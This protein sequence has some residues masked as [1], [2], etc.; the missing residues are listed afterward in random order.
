MPDPHSLPS[1]LGN[2]R[3]QAKLM[4]ANLAEGHLMQAIK[5]CVDF[6]NELRSLAFSP[7]EYYE[8]YMAVYDALDTFSRYLLQLHRLK[9]AKNKDVPFLTDL[10]E[11]VQYTGN[12]VPRL[13]LM[14]AIGTTCMAVENA[15]TK[16]IMKDMI[17]MCRGVQH[18]IRGLFLRHYL[19]QRTKDLF[20]LASMPDFSDTVD[21]LVTN[22]VEMNKL[23][24]RLQHQGH[25]SERDLRYREREELK[26]LV[27]LNLV[28]LSQVLDDF[29]APDYSAAAYYQS[30][31]FPIVT[32]Q[33]IQCKDHL[34]QSYL[35]DVVIQIFPDEYHFA[36]LDSLLNEVFL[37][38]HPMLKKSDFVASLVGRFVTFRESKDDL[39]SNTDQLA[40][41]D[42]KT[43]S[44]F[45][46]DGIFA[47][48]WDFYANLRAQDPPLPREELVPI[49]QL[50][51]KLLLAF[52]GSN[53]LN[54]DKIYLFAAQ[55]LKTLGAL[56]GSEEDIQNAWKE[57]LMTPV[58]HFASVKSL[59]ELPFFYELFSKITNPL[60]QRQLSC[61]IAL[62]LLGSVQ[63]PWHLLTT[64]EDIDNVFKYLQVL[65]EASGT[66]LTTSK[67]LGIEKTIKIDGGDKLITL[68]FLHVQETVCKVLHS[69]GHREEF[70]C[71]SSLFYVKKKYLSKSPE[72][73]VHTY[74]TLITIMT[75]VLR[76]TGYRH[77]A[78]KSKN[79]ADQLEL[80]IS[81]NFKNISIIIDEL[82]QH[83]QQFSAELVL[84]L[85]LNLASV[86]DQLRQE[87]IAYELFNQCFVV[88]EENLV[89]ASSQGQAINPHDSMGGSLSY[90]SVV[91]IANRLASLRYFSKKNYETLITKI[92]L[93][94][95]KLLKKQ[96][97]CRSI[98]QCAHLWWWCDLLIDG[99]SPTTEPDAAAGPILYQDAKRVL[100]CLQKSLRVADSCMDPYLLLKLFVEILNRSLIFNIYDNYMVDSRYI[101]GLID[102]IRTN[103]ANFE[104]SHLS[105][106]DD[107][108]EAKLL[109]RIKD[110]FDRTLEY[111]RGQQDSADR[112]RGI[113]V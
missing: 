55:D 54:L 113:V 95:S 104:Q 40:L 88:Y 5:N 105:G 36:T 112:L 85:Y 27:G 13:Y 108:Q 28:R 49:L 45:S 48:F 100:E 68:E 83:H 18:P 59:L 37:K 46:V 79:R 33:I 29:S 57:L 44:L 30:K 62:K 50:L 66:Q 1:S 52:D 42:A 75:N 65:V 35:I 84:K 25:L 23:W 98:Y 7:K 86:A 77:L 69:I 76:I 24:V 20:P 15:A 39:A 43:L 47:A 34:A 8:L 9:Q 11:L 82:Y 17:E 92:T 67:A 60:L 71:L 102:L 19:C 32:E 74:P 72:N 56:G 91:M 26:I 103:F 61:E 96:D 97:Q 106:V 90:Q 78:R 12:I 70:K 81:S 107:D 4:R 14:I 110:L 64:P 10:Y 99:K 41:E 2:I 93:Y 58:E 80:L 73:I 87:N 53:V 6:L 109:R 38:L 101:S 16:D 31:L 3:H 111:L 51:V 94:G 21:F 22:F 63:D 89:L